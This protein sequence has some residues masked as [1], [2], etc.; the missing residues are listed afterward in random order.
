MNKNFISVGNLV[1][2]KSE[3]KVLYN[4][5]LNKELSEYGIVIEKGVFAGHNDLK[6]LW[7]KNVSTANSSTLTRV[8][9]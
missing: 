8:C 4:A 9:E 5:S 2:F 7:G 6:V 3:F 1:T